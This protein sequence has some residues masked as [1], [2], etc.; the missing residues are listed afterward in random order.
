ML[1]CSRLTVQIGRDDAKAA[2]T[3]GKPIN[4]DETAMD[5][6]AARTAFESAGLGV[7]EVALLFGA[8]GKQSSS[9][10]FV[11]TVLPTRNPW[12]PPA[13]R[14]IHRSTGELRRVV[15]ET[16]AVQQVAASDEESDVRDGDVDFETLVPSTFGS[17][18]KMFGTK[19]YLT[20]ELLRYG[21]LYWLL[22]FLFAP[23]GK[24]IGKGNFGVGYLSKAVKG[25]SPDDNLQSVLLGDP[26]ITE[27]AKKYASSETA[28]L[29]D[30]Q[31]AYLRLTLL[32]QT[33]STRNS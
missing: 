12:G 26:Q 32:G 21:L 2:N 16:L 29:K 15:A 31:E 30:L 33:Y 27:V 23:I 7:K 28:F 25:K 22:L 5:S 13:W 20:L 10:H 11:A 6:R 1:G 14:T 3:R 17:R 9:R 18:D 24:K 19:I 4:W 8:L